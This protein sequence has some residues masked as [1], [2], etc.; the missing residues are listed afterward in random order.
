[1][2][3][4][5]MRQVENQV[6]S[7][8]LVGFQGVTLDEE[9][10]T[11]IREFRIGGVV[12]FKRNI[13]SAEQ[14]HTLLEESQCYALETLGRPLWVAIDQEGGLVQ[15]L[16][17][18]FT[19]LPSA[20]ELASQGPEAV[21]RW[22]RKAALDLRALGIQNNLAPVLDVL[23]EG[24]KHFMDTRCLGSDPRL[25]AELG[26]LWIQGLQNHGVSATAKHYPGLGQAESDPH[27]YAPVI[28][29]RDNDA[30]ERD[31]L[32]FREAVH[33]GVHCVMT[34]HALYPHL[35]ADWPATLSPAIN[36]TW[37][38]QRLG[39]QGVL[40]SD[41]MDMAAVAQRFSWDEMVRQ[42]LLSTIDFFL[43]C[44]CSENI[45]PFHQALCAATVQNSELKERHERSL[46]RIGK[47]PLIQ[48]KV[49][50]DP[51]S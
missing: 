25:V 15:R 16:I 41:D 38:R 50:H 1:M 13:E 49:R 19:H 26:K 37:L 29:W 12:L 6:G 42:G 21:R 46:E 8:L 17:P 18:P 44:Q 23:P 32:P 31:L 24:N 14:L 47:L 51:A 28:Q 35:D 2:T 27:H 4:V 22:S 39:F 5:A 36:H 7:H 43:L 20:R 9:L 30:M 10:R 45:A 40:L 34:S 33:A 48:D 11:I 3:G